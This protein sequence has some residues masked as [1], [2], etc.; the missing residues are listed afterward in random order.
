MHSVHAR[1][2]YI[3]DRF[4]M[5]LTMA[6]TRMA[7]SSMLARMLA[8]LISSGSR[9]PG[10]PAAAAATAAAASNRR[11]DYSAPYQ[12]LQQGRQ[13]DD[14]SDPPLRL[15]ADDDDPASPSHRSDAH[16]T[17]TVASLVLP[18][19][20]HNRAKALAR[21]ELY[22]RRA[23]AAGAEIMVAPETCLDGYC[24]YGVSREELLSLAESSEDGPSI[25]RLRS[26][27][28][29]LSVYLCI[30]FSELSEEGELYN[31]A[32]L[33]GRRGETVG[34]YRKTHGV[35]VAEKNGCAFF[36]I[37]PG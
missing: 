31:T 8:H 13:Q 34:K 2:A 36:S 16:R 24:S 1:D 21:V 18:N 11:G 12:R 23:A 9:P 19:V 22:M 14:E 37:F 7:T 28:H 17:V 27:C 35:E 33:I 5:Y 15:P 6:A 26:L 29:E 10:P 20:R 4:S 25:T 30:G 3:A 32:L